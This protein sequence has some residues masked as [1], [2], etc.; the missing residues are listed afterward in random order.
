MNLKTSKRPSDGKGKRSNI[1]FV[2]DFS[3]SSSRP[4]MSGVRDEDADGIISCLG[5][6]DP[7]AR[8]YA[9]GRSGPPV[10]LVAAGR[11]AATAKRRTISLVCD[12][13]EVGKSAAE[14]LV[15]HDLKEFGFVGLRIGVAEA[16][17]NAARQNAYLDTLKRYGY[18]ARIYGRPRATV[19]AVADAAALSAWLRS[20]PKPCGI[21][22]TNDLRALNVLD[23]CRAEGI[24]VPEQIQIVGVDN[25]P[26][27]CEKTS[28]TLSS[29]E[30]NFEVAG[31]RAADAVMAMIE[32]RKSG[33]D[34]SFGVHRVVQRMSTTDV[35]GYAG[36]ALRARDYI[37]THAAERMTVKSIAR[38]LCCSLRTLQTSYAK[39]FGR[40]VS[41]EI[42]T[43]KV[44]LAQKLLKVGGLSVNE[45]PERIGFESPRHFKRIFKSRTG[46]TMSQ[47]RKSA[48][49]DLS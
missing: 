4:I 46:M 43:V 31:I 12:E 47:W 2:A 40:T 49:T 45:I 5:A 44:S 41:D 17:W 48:L 32:N 21:F 6:K 7:R 9:K 22:A 24:S 16:S 14:L 36:R 26:W 42:A 33:A 34:E 8:W 20:L 3:Y 18:S 25:E 13:T 27:I 39:V 23:A 38:R 29:I 10:V 35:H 28:P 1:L 11:A 19:G 37:A 15:R 30:P